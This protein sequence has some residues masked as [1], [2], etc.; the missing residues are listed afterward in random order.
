MLRKRL[1]R[2]PYLVMNDIF[3]TAD[4]H[5]FH[6]LMVTR[7]GFSSVEEMN[8]RL[9]ENWNAVVKKGDRVYHLGDVSLGKPEPTAEILGRLNGTIY[10]V[11]GNHDSAAENGK[12]RKRF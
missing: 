4:S 2:A 3:Y 10:L 1:Q 9:I 5:W 7:R 6:K 12:C 8:E 11:R